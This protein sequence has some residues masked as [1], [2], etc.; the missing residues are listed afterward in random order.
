MSDLPAL[1]DNFVVWYCPN[2]EYA[3][4]YVKGMKS[5]G[6]MCGKST[7]GRIPEWAKVEVRRVVAQENSNE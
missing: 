7:F 3:T 5:C 6:A 1:S 2:E 4:S